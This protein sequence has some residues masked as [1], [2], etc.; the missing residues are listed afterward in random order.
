MLGFLF[1]VTVFIDFLLIDVLFGLVVVGFTLGLLLLIVWFLCLSLLCCL[2]L[3]S[4]FFD[5]LVLVVCCTYIAGCYWLDVWVCLFGLFVL[6][7]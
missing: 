5:V 1:M 3:I 2:C 7:V 4:C 6:I